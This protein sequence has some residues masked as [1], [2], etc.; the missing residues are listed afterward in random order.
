MANS[1]FQFKHFMIQQDRCAMKVGT[2]G[3]LLG[4][5][6]KAKH[7][8]KILDVGT[9]T[10]LIALMLAQRYTEAIIKGIEI[11]AEASKQAQE[12]VQASPFGERISIE[13][14]SYQDFSEHSTQTYDL[15]VSNPPYFQNSYTSHS[16][17][18]NLARHTHALSYEEL[19]KLSYK[20]LNNNGI[21]SIIIPFSEYNSLIKIAEDNKLFL[22]DILK[23][24]PTQT[25]NCKRVILNFSK[26]KPKNIRSE[27]II[28]EPTQRHQY[29]EA[30][31]ALTQEF[32]IK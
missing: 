24:Y 27:E 2:D 19:L 17:K 25:T 3:V 10:G 12:N 11:E 28:I 29:S 32:Y 18:R 13:H 15:I 21:L 7:P 22:T 1:W 30:F 14:Q 16:H 5:W 9:G 8:R 20:N 26:E 23:I 31:K 6:V 4:A